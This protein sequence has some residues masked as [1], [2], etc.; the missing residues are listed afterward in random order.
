MELVSGNGWTQ[1]ISALA[2]SPV[3]LAGGILPAR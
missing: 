1:A 2:I 3:A